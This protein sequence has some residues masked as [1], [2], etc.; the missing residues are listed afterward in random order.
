VARA[1]LRVPADLAVVGFGDVAAASWT[2]P[3]LTTVG[4]PVAGQAKALARLLL[5]RLEDRPT[6][7][8]VLPTSLVVRDSG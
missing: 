4:V 2:S 3:A 8:V 1:G 6:T 7:S 5:S